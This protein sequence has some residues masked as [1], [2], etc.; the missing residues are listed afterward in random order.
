M[1][2]PR[3]SI[4]QIE[5]E[6]TSGWS[7]NTALIDI[8]QT[9]IPWDTVNR[10]A[11]FNLHA[12]RP[13][14][15][16]LMAHSDHM[17]E[18]LFD[19]SL[20]YAWTWMNQ[21]Q[22]GLL[23]RRLDEI[24]ADCVVPTE[25]S[26]AW[27]DMAVGMRIYEIAYIL[28]VISRRPDTEHNRDTFNL[29]FRSMVVHQ[30]ILSRD[31]F[32]ISHN[33][34]GLYQAL[35]QLAA[36]RRFSFV[37][38]FNAYYE[39]AEKRV[40]VMAPK[41]FLPSGAH[42]EHSPAYH[43]MV[44]GTF[45]GARNSGLITDSNTLEVIDRSEDILAWMIQPNGAIAPIGDTDLKV[46]AA[47][48]HPGDARRFK[49]AATQYALSRGVIGLLPEMGT[50]V[51]QDAGY[52]FAR[53]LGENAN[54]ATS[55]YFAQIAGFHSRTHKHADHLSFLWMERGRSILIDPGKFGYLGKTILGDNLSAQGFFYSDPKRIYVEKTRAHNC[56][57]IDGKDYERKKAKPFGSA[58]VY[59]EET[60]SGLTVTCCKVNHGKIRHL[61]ILVLRPGSFLITIDWLKDKSGQPHDYRQWFQLA[62]EWQT[63]VK[64]GI[65]NATHKELLDFRISAGSLLS[66]PAFDAIRKGQTE[67][68]MSGWMSDQC[69]SLVPCA[70]T[71]WRL[72]SA[73]LARFATIFSLTRELVVD[74]KFS[75]VSQSSSKG[76]LRWID[77]EGQK[78]LL[79]ERD[80]TDHTVSVI[81]I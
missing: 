69:H 74:Q 33:N 36:S 34:H 46:P 40:G 39:L 5:R 71:N 29:F 75:F 41:M 77:D 65:L 57:E 54:Y 26:R 27:Y 70:S 9:E 28:D 16:L 14:A 59:A 73:P 42:A 4:A 12:W 37:P 53:A 62:P 72:D 15:Y 17:S 1:A 24:V 51:I 32:F 2:P 61:R 22:V 76:R 11:S 19:I 45:I 10:S 18:R 52:V 38:G 81:L 66:E 68:E 78:T 47:G 44:L 20:Q 3:L 79:F 48:R 13:L 55:T 58:L 25:E 64:D 67:P 23:D 60:K 50:K 43:E 6:I 8:T 30:E 21:F 31:D 63:R 35:G 7:L 49:N 56:V 80:T